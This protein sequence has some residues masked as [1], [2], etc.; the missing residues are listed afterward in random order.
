MEI[1]ELR[2]ERS[3]KITGEI[4]RNGDGDSKTHGERKGTER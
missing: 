1:W 4:F 3:R 2:K